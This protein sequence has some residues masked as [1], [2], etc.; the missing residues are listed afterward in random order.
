MKSVLSEMV[1]PQMQPIFAIFVSY[2]ASF[3]VENKAYPLKFGA[4]NL[5]L[6]TIGLCINL[7]IRGSYFRLVWFFPPSFF[8]LDI[9]LW[10]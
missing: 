7:A 5:G 8:L 3:N 9:F 4:W 2:V 1:L 10:E 6:K